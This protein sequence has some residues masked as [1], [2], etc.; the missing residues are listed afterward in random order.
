MLAREAAVLDLLYGNF[1]FDRRG[2]ELSGQ[3][4]SLLNPN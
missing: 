2:E 4:T 3:P 1:L